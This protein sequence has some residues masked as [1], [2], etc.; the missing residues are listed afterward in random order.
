[1]GGQYGRGDLK[2]FLCNT[3]IKTCLK[4]KEY[5][6][7]KKVTQYSDIQCVSWEKKTTGGGKHF[8][9]MKDGFEG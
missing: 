8:W 9:Q 6:R 5:N 4:T 1:M 2:A 3:I 7:N